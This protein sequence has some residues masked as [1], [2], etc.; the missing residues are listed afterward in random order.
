MG[1]QGPNGARP[2][3]SGRDGGRERAAA[4]PGALAD[5][6]ELRA[7]GAALARTPP[8]PITT[9][10]VVGRLAG[11]TREV[12]YL[13]ALAERL[14]VEHNLVTA[15]ALEGACYA[16]RFSRAVPAAAD[17]GAALAPAGG[18][19]SRLRRPGTA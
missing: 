16:I 19:R 1:S 12:R 3:A 8:T 4:G 5:R 15:F 11:T 13:R 10:T 6:W 7:A 9:I 2:G 18:V 17:G 14:A